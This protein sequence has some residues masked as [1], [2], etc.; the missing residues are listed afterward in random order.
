V[1]ECVNEWMKVYIDC[2]DGLYKRLCMCMNVSLCYDCVCMYEWMCVLIP[3]NNTVESMFV[4]MS[5]WVSEQPHTSFE[6][7]QDCKYQ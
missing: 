5:E 6:S 7:A 1:H 4:C 3:M 2:V